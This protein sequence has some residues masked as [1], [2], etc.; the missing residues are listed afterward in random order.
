MQMF[1]KH[2]VLVIKQKNFVD[3]LG[4]VGSWC[5]A[6]NMYTGWDSPTLFDAN[7]Q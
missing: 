6:S 3:I 5:V 4:S 1:F 2:N 7:V